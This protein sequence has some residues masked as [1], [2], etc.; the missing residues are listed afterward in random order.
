[1]MNIKELRKEVQELDKKYKYEKPDIWDDETIGKQLLLCLDE[2][3]RADR[4]IIMLY[5]EYGSLR[6][7][8][9]KLGCSYQSVANEVNRIKEIMI[10]KQKKIEK[11]F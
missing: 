8:A 3:E 6:E 1:M 11:W 7:V 4:T 5:A 9:K 2:L 10:S